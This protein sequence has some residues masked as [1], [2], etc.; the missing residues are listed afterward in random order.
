MFEKSKDLKKS[1]STWREG[2]VPV[3]TR[4][5]KVAAIEVCFFFVVCIYHQNRE[6]F[7]QL[8]RPK[9]RR[10]NTKETFSGFFSV[11]QN[12]LRILATWFLFSSF[13]SQWQ[14]SKQSTKKRQTETKTKTNTKNEKNTRRNKISTIKMNR[15]NK[16]TVQ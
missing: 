11:Q 2:K 8:V 13:L 9:W 5:E 7:A 14:I 6:R 16:Q 1:S 10:S 3:C 12:I 15:I 4:I